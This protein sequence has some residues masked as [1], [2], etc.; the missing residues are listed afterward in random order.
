MARE[1]DV[2]MEKAEVYT[3]DDIAEFA[4]YRARKSAE[5]GD[6]WAWAYWRNTA[7]WAAFAVADP[8]LADPESWPIAVE[9][10]MKN[11]NAAIEAKRYGDAAQEYA[12]AKWLRILSLNNRLNLV[13]PLSL[14]WLH[15]YEGIE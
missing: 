9:M 5:R 14:E 8:L 10:F 6:P 12:H 3:F 15:D 13:K 11:V 4:R 1:E 7:E 2:S